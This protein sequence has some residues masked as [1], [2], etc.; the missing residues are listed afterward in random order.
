M[1]EVAQ[2]MDMVCNIQLLIPLGIFAAV[3][4]IKALKVQNV[5]HPRCVILVEGAEECEFDI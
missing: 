2:M 5:P 4:A 3:S 1:E